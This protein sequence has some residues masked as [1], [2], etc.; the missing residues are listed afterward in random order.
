LERS[1]AIIFDVG[2]A[3][4]PKTCFHA[5][6]A[7]AGRAMFNSAIS[8]QQYQIKQGQ[9]KAATNLATKIQ[10][11]KYRNKFSNAQGHGL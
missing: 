3:A 11:R 10:Q 4:R 1:S 2:T 5:Y 6:V 7:P 9:T 8:I